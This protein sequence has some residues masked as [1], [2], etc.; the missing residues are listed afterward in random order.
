MRELKIVRA[1]F[2]LLLFA[3]YK[4]WNSTIFPFNIKN[5]KVVIIRL[6]IICQNH[7]RITPS[8]MRSIKFTKI[9]RLIFDEHLKLGSSSSLFD[10]LSI[11][12]TYVGFS[13]LPSAAHEINTWALS[14]TYKKELFMIIIAENIENNNVLKKKSNI[15]F[16]FQPL[17]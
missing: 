13:P 1:F 4:E 11:V 2:Y 6:F 7:Q 16:R 17:E 10:H 12:P 3:L 9:N 5:I 15:W 14:W 8:N